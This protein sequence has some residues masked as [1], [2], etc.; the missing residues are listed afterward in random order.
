MDELSEGQYKALSRAVSA[1]QSAGERKRKREI[2]EYKQHRADEVVGAR[3]IFANFCRALQE[4]HEWLSPIFFYS[5]WYSRPARVTVLLIVTLSRMFSQAFLY[6]I[7]AP[8]VQKSDVSGASF[9]EGI[10]GES[11]QIDAAAAIANFDFASKIYLGVF[12]SVLTVPIALLVN[13]LFKAYASHS[14]HQYIFQELG[15]KEISLHASASHFSR[16]VHMRPVSRLGGPVYKAKKV[17]IELSATATQLALVAY[18]D[19][20]RKEIFQIV[21]VTSLTVALH[22][23]HKTKR[24]GG[25]GEDQGEDGDGMCHIVRIAT[26]SQ[27]NDL[28]MNEIDIF[29]WDD[30]AGA[31]D[32]CEKIAKGIGSLPKSLPNAQFEML[33]AKG[34]LR[35]RLINDK[36]A[37]KR[38]CCGKLP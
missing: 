36:K 29:F 8:D 28:E 1:I 7:S 19:E 13:M 34:S 3:H 9:A 30:A 18:T 17:Y 35:L 27:E 25:L 14:R 37:M 21:H 20:S 5:P 10:S 32:W 15:E 22:Q 12:A 6:E 38:C 31:E 24:R 2:A 11:I 16:W 26:P 33:V 23:T 4:E